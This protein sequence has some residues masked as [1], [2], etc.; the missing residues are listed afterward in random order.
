M[1]P[2]SFEAALRSARALHIQGAIQDATK[3]YDALLRIA[4]NHPELLHLRGIAALQ[5]GENVLGVAHLKRAVDLRPTHAEARCN[6]GNG[7]RAL[8][9]PDDALAAYAAALA[10]KPNLVEARTNRGETYAALGRYQE[11]LADFEAAMLVKPEHVPAMLG[12]AGALLALR[13]LEATL[14]EV[15]RVLALRPRS[16]P[17]LVLRARALMLGRKWAMALISLD[18]ALALDS[19]LH[20]ARLYRGMTLLELG[21]AVEA[22]AAF[23]ALLADGRYDPLALLCRANL[24]LGQRRLS[25]ALADF[26]SLITSGAELDF[27]HGH[28][29]HMKMRLCDWTRIDAGY[30]EVEA[31]ILAGQKASHPMVMLAVRDEPE[32]HLRC[33]ARFAPAAESLRLPRRA[34]RDTCPQ[35]YGITQS[36]ISS[37]AL[38]STM[39]A[40][41]ST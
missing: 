14:S 10:L 23:D 37:R 17:A 16:G 32:M 21:R 33:A 8:Q 15:E 7:Y 29:L 6:L 35:T 22:L 2:V 27:V 36:R 18:E 26:E 5:V 25:E 1:P 30:A 19:G 4:P 11:A 39:I 12:R 41:A 40:S 28:W 9:R 20:D 3:R 38:S 13:K 31:R 24:H 34:A